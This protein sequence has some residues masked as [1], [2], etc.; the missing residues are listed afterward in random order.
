MLTLMR[1]ADRV[2]VSMLSPP[3]STGSCGDII[4]PPTLQPKHAKTPF[5]YP[6]PTTSTRFQKVDPRI[7]A[8]H[9]R[10]FFL[11]IENIASMRREGIDPA[12]GGVH[13]HRLVDPY[14]GEYTRH[15]QPTN[16]GLLLTTGNFN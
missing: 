15:D 5:S 12:L 13:G 16:K 6:E 11:P 14:V 8:V 4:T 2:P 1:E 7:L 9:D 10:S 3:S